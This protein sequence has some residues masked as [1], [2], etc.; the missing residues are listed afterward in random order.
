VG[1]TESNGSDIHGYQKTQQGDAQ[2]TCAG[3]AFSNP[4]TS[5]LARD[6]ANTSPSRS[7]SGP[8]EALSA[9]NAGIGSAGG[10]QLADSK[11]VLEGQSQAGLQM[12]FQ[13]LQSIRMANDTS[14][15]KGNS[16]SVPIRE[17]RGFHSV[18]LDPGLSTLGATSY[19]LPPACGVRR[20]LHQ[21]ATAPEAPTPATSYSLPAT[22][23]EALTSPSAWFGFRLRAYEGWRDLEKFFPDGEGELKENLKRI[24]LEKR[25]FPKTEMLKYQ[26]AGFLLRKWGGLRGRIFGHR[27][28]GCFRATFMTQ[29]ELN[30]LM[31]SEEKMQ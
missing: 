16:S 11:G 27:V 31:I 4:F 18:V 25:K 15:S 28:K 10:N 9:D 1:T 22:A 17:I 19:S 26:A 13:K 12:D 23:P 7:A 3:A 2:G 30:A 14:A 29:A 8:A 21:A 24:F 5:E 6:S 20:L